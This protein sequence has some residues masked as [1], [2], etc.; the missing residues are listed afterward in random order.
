MKDKRRAR[1]KKVRRENKDK[2]ERQIKYICLDCG[3][4][5]LIPEG[6]VQTFDMYDDGDIAEPPRF[7]CE[8][9]GGSMVPEDYTGVDGVHYTINNYR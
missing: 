3:M 1:L 9:C 7:Q 4:E 2:E 5:E 6:V 8:N